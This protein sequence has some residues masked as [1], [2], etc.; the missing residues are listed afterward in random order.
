VS[1]SCHK[2]AI[3][4]DKFCHRSP[5]EMQGSGCFAGISTM[6]LAGLCL[7][8]WVGMRYLHFSF[9][10]ALFGLGALVLAGCSGSGTT[11]TGPGAATSSSSPSAG[12]TSTSSGG[13]GGGTTLNGTGRVA[14]MMTDSPFQDASAVLITISE[15]SVHRADGGWEPLVLEGGSITCDLKLLE[16]PTDFLGDA[17]LLAGKYTQIRLTV[18][19]GA[20][21]FGEAPG[22]SGDACVATSELVPPT[23]PSAP[24]TVPS[25]VVRLNRPFTVPE[26]GEAMIVLDFDG[27]RSIRKMGNPNATCDLEEPAP[28]VVATNGRGGG[29]GNSSTCEYRLDPVISVVSVEETE[30]PEEPEDS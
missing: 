1:A 28:A 23:D 9:A 6:Q 25:G 30:G 17:V 8:A 14:V 5:L 13:T 4:D 12:L 15:I 20:I 10:T 7:A 24:V 22:E 18:E 2:V 27:D 16:G 29:S 19:S 21:Y 11:L 26:G 3:H